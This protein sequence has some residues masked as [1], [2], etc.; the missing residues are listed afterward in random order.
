MTLLESPDLANKDEE[1]KLVAERP[2]TLVHSA[3]ADAMDTCL[4]R[5]ECGFTRGFA[6]LQLIGNTSEVC[7]DG[8][9][10]ARAALEDLG[11]FIPA[12]RLVVSL[13]PADVKKDGSHL[14]LPVAVSIALLLL[15]TEPAIDPSRWLFAAELGLKGELR[16]VRGVVSFAVAAMA[17]RMSGMVV[18]MENLEELGVVKALG[19]QDPPLHILGFSTLKEVL[20]WMGTG[21]LMHA[22]LAGT[23]PIAA[24]AEG[25]N[26]DDMVLTPEL[27]TAALV[28]GA[29][30]HSLLLRGT[31]GTGK[32]M[33]AAR[34]ASILP[35]LE[36]DE[37]IEAMRIHSAVAE[38][39]AR[40][41][42][43]GR[44][45]FRAPHHQASAAAVLG[46]G[47]QP[48]ELALAHGGVL[49]LDELPE[50]RR[51]LIEA[52]REP[53]ETGEIRVSRTRR[54][55][56]WKARIILLAACNNCP[57]GWAGSARR[58]CHC[59]S[60]RQIQYN[61]RLSGP[62]LDRIDLHINV[63]EPVERSGDLLAALRHAVSKT[64]GMRVRVAAAREFGRARNRTF[65]VTCNRDLEPKH[66]AAASGLS[67]SAFA[68]LVNRHVP[69]SASRRAAVRSLRVARTVADLAA[70]D[71]IRDEDLKRAWGWQ[72]EPAAL[73]RGELV[74]R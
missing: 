49:F 68:A 16:P 22:T 27:E 18:A 46:G 41:L 19:R 50:F 12:Q 59:S 14:D 63:P 57:C 42:L 21:S 32:S 65:G 5:I 29:G 33:F 30:Q 39:L 51:D 15:P 69:G 43:G 36:R 34:L 48:G 54:K 24:V 70:S 3:V 45:P 58:T 28:I 53:L 9:E 60:Q 4:M 2:A 71:V 10:R 7:R 6:G 72:A 40:G 23:A 44:P 73:A 52:L 8:K 11:L 47:E 64:E 37:H 55:L 25:P 17:K 74:L 13:T 20:A 31:P 61:Q 26:F 56:T 1:L 38:R 62:I 35:P 67:E 66:L